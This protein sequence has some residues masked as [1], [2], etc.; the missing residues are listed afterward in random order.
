MILKGTN[1]FFLISQ[2]YHSTSQC[3]RQLNVSARTLNKITATVSF[4]PG[5]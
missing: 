1:G 3:A 4:E 5:N 2:Q